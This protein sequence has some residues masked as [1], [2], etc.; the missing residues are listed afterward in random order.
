MHKNFKRFRNC[1]MYDKFYQLR[2]KHKSLTKDSCNNYTA[3]TENC[4][5]LNI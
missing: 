5:D 2:I 4:I 1:Q 3:Y